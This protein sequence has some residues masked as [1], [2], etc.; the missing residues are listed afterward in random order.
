MKCANLLI[1]K[2]VIEP[3]SSS[4]CFV[5]VITRLGEGQ[6]HITETLPRFGQTLFQ[7]RIC[8]FLENCF[9]RFGEV[10]LALRDLVSAGLT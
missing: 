3:D 1:A 2:N 5:D 4:F 10:T 9:T 6:P 7:I 8:D